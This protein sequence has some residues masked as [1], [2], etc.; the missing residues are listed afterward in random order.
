MADAVQ[1]TFA[2]PWTKRITKQLEYRYKDDVK[3][4]PAIDAFA[5]YARFAPHRMQAF[6]LTWLRH[7]SGMSCCSIYHLL[8]AS[9]WDN[10]D[11][12]SGVL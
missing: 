3:R 5:F 1:A 12:I 11:C 4:A 7:P 10:N 6:A 9:F 2:M 8:Q